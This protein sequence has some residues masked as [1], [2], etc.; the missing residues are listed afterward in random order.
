MISRPAG[1][2]GSVAPRQ[3]RVARAGTLLGPLRS[4]LTR[5]LVRSRLREAIFWFLVQIGVAALFRYLNKDKLLIIL[6]H[7]VAGDRSSHCYHCP[8][9]SEFRWQ[10]HFIL[11]HYKV[12]PL[13]EATNRLR[14]GEP[15]PPYSA[16]LTFDDGLANNYARVL[17]ALRAMGGCA[18][19]FLPTGHIDSGALLWPE[20]LFLLP[21][22]TKATQGCLSPGGQHR[23]QQVRPCG[24]HAARG[25]WPPHDLLQHRYHAASSR[26][27]PL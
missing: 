16:C 25:R 10:L 21:Q 14:A 17:P 9:E 15:L 26:A 8:S 6:Y 11:S 7:G 23:S 3:Q 18:T 22:E 12:I 24:S 4:T 27:C 2:E 19:V 20:E 5:S 1:R 13:S